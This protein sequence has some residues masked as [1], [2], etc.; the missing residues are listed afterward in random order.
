MKITKDLDLILYFLEELEISKYKLIEKKQLGKNR[1]NFHFLKEFIDSIPIIRTGGTGFSKL[2]KTTHLSN[3]DKL[4][5]LLN[6]T[7][8]KIFIESITIGIS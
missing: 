8:E 2:I 4:I 1:K 7:E 5:K 3:I 6:D